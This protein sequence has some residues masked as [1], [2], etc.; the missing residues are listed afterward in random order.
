MLFMY[1]IN[2]WCSIFDNQS[3]GYGNAFWE[4]I[5]KSILELDW[6]SQVNREPFIYISKTMDVITAIKNQTVER[7]TT[8]T[9]LVI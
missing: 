4:Q 9:M 6:G 8:K 3:G 7:H 1:N 5:K 2:Q